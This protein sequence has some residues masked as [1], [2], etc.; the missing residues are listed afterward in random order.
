MR[1]EQMFDR[2]CIVKETASLVTALKPILAD[3]TPT[4]CM[5]PALKQHNP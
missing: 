3:V 2:S 5:P 4:T 1:D